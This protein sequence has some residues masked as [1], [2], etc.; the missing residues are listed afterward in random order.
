MKWL[1]LCLCFLSGCG[2]LFPPTPIPPVP[3][4]IGSDTATSLSEVLRSD[5]SARS[6]LCYEIAKR[7]S[8]PEFEPE[9]Y[10]NDGDKRIS[11][12]TNEVLRKL[13]K[14]RLDKGPDEAAWNEIGKGYGLR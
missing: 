7:V 9:E 14:G 5:R 13:I 12:K 10:W 2:Q 8:E 6:A 3:D 1:V 11:E 4:P